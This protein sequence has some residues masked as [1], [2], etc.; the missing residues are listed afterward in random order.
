MT[1]LDDGSGFDVITS[2]RT[3]PDTTDHLP[4]NSQIH[5]PSSVDRPRYEYFLTHAP[6]IL[7][8]PESVS[9][10]ADAIT[11][12]AAVHTVPMEANLK[13]KV[14]RAVAQLE[15]TNMINTGQ[16]SV[17]LNESKRV[18]E[19]ILSRFFPEHLGE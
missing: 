2:R 3:P 6:F 15:A 17:P 16:S 12:G 7:V 8:T 19:E 9:M 14:A 18:A 11:A 5:E 13:S 1:Q 4:P 10:L